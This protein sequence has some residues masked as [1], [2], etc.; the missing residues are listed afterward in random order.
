MEL[1]NIDRE[2]DHKTLLYSEMGEKDSNGCFNDGMQASTGCT[3]G[4][5]LFKLLG[6]GKPAL[7]MYRK[8]KGAVRVH[9]KNEFLDELSSRGA[10]FFSLRKKGVE[11]SEIPNE[12][13]DPI[14][15]EWLYGLSNDQIFEHEFI[16]DFHPIP[17]KSTGIRRKCDQCNEY[18]YEIDLVASSGK[19]ICKPDY[20]NIPENQPT[21]L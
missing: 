13:I 2:K 3:Y 19:L 20:Y 18:V 7:I 12:A 17:V 10:E 4:K 21:K 6:Y 14:I 8:D 11:P 15:N 5:G 9:V 1:L 16:K